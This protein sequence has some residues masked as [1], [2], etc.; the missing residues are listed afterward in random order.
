MVVSFPA[1]TSETGQMTECGNYGDE[2]RILT[3]LMAEGWE[4]K[5]ANLELTLA[6]SF[7]RVGA[8]SQKLSWHQ[9][10]D[11]SRFSDLKK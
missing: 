9:L 10:L 11:K 3:P 8:T 2:N 6:G 4:V 7:N 5:L 1:R